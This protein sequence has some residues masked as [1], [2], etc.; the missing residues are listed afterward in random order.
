QK[1]E[2]GEPAVTLYDLFLGEWSGKFSSRALK[3]HPVHLRASLIYP[4]ES[5]TLSPTSYSLSYRLW[6]DGHPTHSLMLSTAGERV[7]NCITLSEKEVQEEMEIAYFCNLHPGTRILINGQKATTFQLGDKVKIVSK[8]HAIELSFVLEE[9]EG[10]FWG[11]LYRGNR[12]GQ[13]CCRGEE[14]HEAFDWVIGLRT[15]KRSAKATIRICS[16]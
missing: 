9:G 16:F 5:I 7:E 14:K 15:V 1:Q 2:R 13:L 11:H 3:D 12:P 6:G 8:D 4:S 10:Q